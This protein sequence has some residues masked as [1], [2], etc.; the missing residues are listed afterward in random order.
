LSAE[1][2]RLLYRAVDLA[3]VSGVARW[4]GSRR[5]VPGRNTPSR[6]NRQIFLR[7]GTVLDQ[8]KGS[9]EKQ[10]DRIRNYLERNGFFDSKVKISATEGGSGA[11]PNEGMKIDTKIDSGETVSVRKVEITGVPEKMR[12]DIEDDFRHYWVFHIFPRRFQPDS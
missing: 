2:R 5:G 9:L 6:S 1:L 11:Q 7:P 12:E 4:Q 3:V 8:E 10:E